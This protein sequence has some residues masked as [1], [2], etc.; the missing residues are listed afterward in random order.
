MKVE[1]R[2]LSIQLYELLTC[3]AQIIT[4]MTIIST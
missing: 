2:L 3:R 4:G 1:A